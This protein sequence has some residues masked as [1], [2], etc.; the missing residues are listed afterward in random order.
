VHDVCVLAL[1]GVVAFDLAVPVEVFTRATD[2]D[3]ERAYRVRI[4]AAGRAARSGLFTLRTEHD[5]SALADAG[6]I[7]V[8][9]TDDVS[10]PT[11]PAVLAALRA[12][13]LS[14]VRIASVCSGAFVLAE[15]GLLD[16]L[17][18]TTH[19]LAAPLLAARYPGIRVD[20]DVLY[21]DEGRILTSAGAA[22]GL[23][24]C[25]HL[26]RRDL[27][28]DAAGHAARLCVMP[29]ERAGGQA[30]F[31]E[32]ATPGAGGGSLEAALEWT[33]RHLHEP[34]RV[35]DLARRV[36]M[37]ERTFNRR[38][39]EQVGTTPARWL[40]RERVLRAQRLLESSDLPVEQVA[41]RVGFGS[42][43]T[44]R[45]RFGA[46]VGTSPQAWR[47]AFRAATTPRLET[48]DRVRSGVAE[49]A[50]NA[51]EYGGRVR[52]YDS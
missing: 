14:S 34:L 38:F 35:V 37:S 13:A 7:I 27:G 4:C 6:T 49:V 43:V 42:A 3:G 31:I 18:A 11:P 40:A 1:D 41:D 50:P 36:G 24:L 52:T 48:D 28:A 20:P 46:V 32:H 16:G 8:P 51:G 30:Q 5:L 22:A 26:V 44:L 17:R 23:D 39:R 10:Q 45:Q 47:Q 15:A 21:V 29:L 33:R 19:W 2:R 25:L 9:G 12:A